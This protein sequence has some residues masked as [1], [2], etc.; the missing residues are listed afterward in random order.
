M[1]NQEFIKFKQIWNEKMPINVQLVFSF[2]F[3]E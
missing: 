2:A 1:K 3:C